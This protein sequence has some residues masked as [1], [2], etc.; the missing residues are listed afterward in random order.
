VVAAVAVGVVVAIGLVVFA[1]R[2]RDHHQEPPAAP[3]TA[4]AAWGARPDRPVVV[5]R[6]TIMGRS[7]GRVAVVPL[8]DPSGPRSLA[9]LS[10]ERVDVAAGR[11]ICLT[12]DRG[13]TTRYRALVVDRRF[14][15]LHRLD[16]PGLPSRARVSPDGRIAA[17]TV[18]VTGDSYA[19]T[20]FS[21]RT[22]LADLR[23][24]AELG[25]L[26]R[27]RVTHDGRVVD[28][29]DRNYWGVTFAADS[30]HFYATL[31]TGGETYL[32]HGSVSTRAAEVVHDHVECPSLSPE[33]T[34]IAYKWRPPGPGPVRWQVHVLDLRTGADHPVADDRD[35]DDQVE[36]LDDRT[37]VYA[38]PRS[39][40][41]TAVNDVWRVPAD[42][43]GSPRVLVAG[44]WS[45]SVVR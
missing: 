21:T 11:G 5:F 41:N 8:A 24:G 40:T 28:A 36:W 32:I 22:I 26:E 42:G 23:T 20:N 33:G 6:N 30:D 2:E 44:A 15:V 16:L 7:F 17:M 35:V 29:V 37:L 18:F 38:L 10:C 9:P 31:Q 1:G 43:T 14:R 19:A 25:N 39:A 3:T 27:F 34:R 13:S 12:A 45:P 4:P